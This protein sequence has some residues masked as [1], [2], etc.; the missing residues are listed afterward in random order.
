MRNKKRVSKFI[1]IVSTLYFVLF[2]FSFITTFADKLYGYS[3]D[4]S[5]IG[6]A[7]YLVLIDVLLVLVSIIYCCMNNFIIYR[8][9]TDN[10]LSEQESYE[11]E[12]INANNQVKVISM[13]VSN[14]FFYFLCN[15]INY[16]ERL[17]F[18][19]GSI[20][21]I[22]IIFEIVSLKRIE[23]ARISDDEQL[24][25][26]RFVK[27]ASYLAVIIFNGL[28]VLSSV[29]YINSNYGVEKVK[30]FYAEADDCTYEM[31]KSSKGGT[32]YYLY[33]VDDDNGKRYKFRIDERK[34]N[35]RSIDDYKIKVNVYRG[36]LGL[37]WADK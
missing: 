3:F 35:S 11:M 27:I 17:F 29:L 24:G 13:M 33:V 15:G 37:E 22:L 31:H 26:K 7:K 19:C 18:I 4:N 10:N 9:I 8:K 1:K 34:Y 2:I 28:Y 16:C 20:S 36:I 6:I 23:S 32:S 30:T 25:A 14:M 12:D 5:K 21:L